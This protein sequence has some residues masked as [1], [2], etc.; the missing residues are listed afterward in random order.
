MNRTI[1]NPEFF[2][3]VRCKE[4]SSQYAAFIKMIKADPEEYQA[5]LDMIDRLDF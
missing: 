5:F 3:Y 1:L 2:I 4:N